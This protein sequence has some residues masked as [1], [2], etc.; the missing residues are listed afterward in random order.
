[1]STP[2]LPIRLRE[3]DRGALETHFLRLGA[4]DRR[5]RFGG[6]IADEGLRAYVARIDFER[7]GVFAVHDD[8][9]RLVAVVHVAFSEASAE[10]GLSVLPDARGEGLGNALL[11]RAVMHLRN[12]GS[13]E[14]FVHC[15]TE[16]AAMMHLARKNGMRIIP[17]GSESDARLAIDPPT[18]HSQF[19]E[20]LQ[21]NQASVIQSVR[22]NARFSR[23]LLEFF[24]PAGPR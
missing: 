12:R 18:P 20:W 17:A 15:L 19:A 6:P 13:P 7:D 2:S 10:L 8:D 14:V 21:D 3:S 1:M 11:T 16:N 24:N 22:R 23:T 5:L 9:L 4:E